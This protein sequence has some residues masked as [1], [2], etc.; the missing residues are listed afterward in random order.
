MNVY[1]LIEKTCIPYESDTMSIVKIFLNE[2]VARQE[3]KELN[4]EKSLDVSYD[5]EEHFVDEL[6]AIY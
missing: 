2:D 4:K 1:V 3:L 6:R 5:I